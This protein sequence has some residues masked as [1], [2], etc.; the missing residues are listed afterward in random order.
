MLESL[1]IHG[2]RTFDHLQIERLGRVNLIVGK[3][4]VGKTTLLEALRLYAGR[5][6]PSLILS[7]LHDHDEVRRETAMSSG[8]MDVYRLAF[9]EERVRLAVENLFHGRHALA[10]GVAH[11]GIGP[12]RM[13]VER[14]Q[15][16][17]EWFEE[18]EVEGQRR[19]SVVASDR[20]EIAEDP[21]LAL[22]SQYA[23]LRKFILPVDEMDLSLSA[24]ERAYRSPG[25]LQAD[26]LKKVELRVSYLPADGLQPEQSVHFWDNIALTDLEE[27]V[28]AAI[29][30]IEPEAQ[31]ISQ[32]GDPLNPQGRVFVVKLP[33]LDRPVPLRSMGDGMRRVLGI[34]LALVNAQ[35][36][37]LL[38][39]EFENGLH[40]TV[41]PEVWRLIFAVAH[42][43]NVQVFATTHSWD[44]LEAFQEAANANEEVEG[45][46]IRL[47]RKK[48]KLRVVPFDEEDL[49]V[50]ASRHIEVR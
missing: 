15:I 22:T 9:G 44:C 16:A 29:Q 30:I 26:A 41:Q 27:Q 32:V 48:D 33:G 1:A 3:N 34:A 40:Y 24:G 4:N 31:R 14:V 7:I 47:E 12:S 45:Q 10:N 21:R 20:K 35:G 49:A 50:V 6:A 38:V 37:M 23:D 19:R 43:L 13:S 39:D 18:R 42:R 36:G 17:L 46:L 2:F 25:W 8:P 5:G 11:I 28:L